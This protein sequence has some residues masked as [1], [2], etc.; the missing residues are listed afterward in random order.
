MAGLITWLGSA[1][2][3]TVP[4]WEYG[5]LVHCVARLEKD[6]ADKAYRLD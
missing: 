4:L 2:D 5:E 3:T 6:W 1:H